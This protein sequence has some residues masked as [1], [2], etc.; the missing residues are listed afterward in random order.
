MPVASRTRRS[1]LLC[2]DI[3]DKRRLGRLHRFLSPQAQFIQYSVYLLR[4]TEA[5][6][7]LLLE[8][9]RDYIDEAEDDVRVYPMT[10]ESA[11]LRY[12]EKNFPASI[13]V[14]ER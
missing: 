3:A 14:Y 6:L 5:E 8:E 13:F 1:W 2:Y 4:V 7:K 10:S 9:V 12:G 11:L